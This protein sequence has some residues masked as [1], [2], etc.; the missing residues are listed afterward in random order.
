MANRPNTGGLQLFLLTGDTGSG[1]SSF[2]QVLM[3]K[4]KRT[5]TKTAGFV[6]PSVK[7]ENSS[8]SYNIKDLNTGKTLRLSSRKK[9]EGWM[10]TGG[11]Y[12]NSAGIDLGNSVLSDPDICNND[13]VVVDEVGPFELEDMIWAE[14]ITRLL[15]GG[16]CSMLWVVRKHL[17]DKVIQKW[18]IVNP[19]I[20]DNELH[21]AD[22]ALEIILQGLKRKV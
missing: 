6:S 3:E 1:K 4:F 9:Q 12:F 20:L 19:V 13:L 10:K 14:A 15:K 5:G 8:S 17:V 11:F 16:S 2:L 18:K 21:T 7:D 22:Q